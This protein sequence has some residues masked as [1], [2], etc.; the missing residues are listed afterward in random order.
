MLRQSCSPPASPLYGTE[1]VP[2][3]VSVVLVEV[4]VAAFA[5]PSSVTQARLHGDEKSRDSLLEVLPFLRI[6]QPAPRTDGTGILAVE[7][8]QLIKLSVS[9]VVR[10]VS[11][12]AALRRTVALAAK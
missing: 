1:R 3:A 4:K 7:A 8:A 11:G 2:V 10:F 6:E 5:S 9:A 12:A